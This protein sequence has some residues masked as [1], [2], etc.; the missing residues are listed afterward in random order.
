[1]PHPVLPRHLAYFPFHVS[2]PLQL[3]HIV[4][5]SHTIQAALAASMNA[6]SEANLQTW[7]PLLTRRHLHLLR[8]DTLWWGTLCAKHDCRSSR[9][10]RQ[11]M[12]LASVDWDSCRTALNA[13]LKSPLL[14]SLSLSFDCWSTRDIRAFITR[15]ISAVVCS[16]F[17]GSRCVADPCLPSTTVIEFVRE[18]P[19]VVV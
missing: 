5:L 1:M 18:L 4:I 17:Y 2:Q 3:Q 9:V 8:R 12:L 6:N 15:D 10:R 11:E 13:L 14:K 16:Y 7:G 19:V